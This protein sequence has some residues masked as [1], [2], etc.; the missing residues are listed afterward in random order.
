MPGIGCGV[1]IHDVRNVLRRF[2]ELLYVGHFYDCND[3]L[4]GRIL[5]QYGPGPGEYGPN[6]YKPVKKL[7]H[8]ELKP[9]SGA[10]GR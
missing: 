10:G 8:S 5:Q 7:L 2:C 4:R 3:Y 9:G 1:V 6:L